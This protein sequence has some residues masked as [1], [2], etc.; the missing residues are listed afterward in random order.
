MIPDR[1]M[2]GKKTEMYIL[3]YFK[4]VK[5]NIA[6]AFAILLPIVM[7]AAGMAIDMAQAYH[8]KERLCGALDLAAVSAAATYTDQDD[9]TSRLNTVIKENFV[10]GRI[11]ELTETEVIVTDDDVTAKAYGVYKTAF[12]HAIGRDTMNVNCETTVKRDVRGLEVALVLDVTGSMSGSNI[13][14]L[15]TASKN[16][17]DIIYD[18]TSDDAFVKIGLVPYSIAVNVGEIAP[19][20]VNNNL[21]TYRGAQVPY[22]YLTEESRLDT[23]VA[24]HGCVKARAYPYDALDESVTDGGYWEP[25]WAP[26]TPFDSKD[27]HWD[28]DFDDDDGDAGMI[29]PRQAECNDRRTPN[30]GCPE[31]N[32]IVPLTSDKQKLIEATENLEFWCRGGTLGNLGMTWGHRILSPGLPFEEGADYDDEKWQ[33]VAVM[34]TDGQNQF[35]DKRTEQSGKDSDFS[36]YGYFLDGSHPLGPS[37]P[38]GTSKRNAEDLMQE[39]FMETCNAMKAD[40]IEIYTIVFGDRL[41]RSSYDGLR[42]DF[43]NCASKPANYYLAPSQADLIAAFEKISKELSIIH[44]TN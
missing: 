20:I 7:G 35:F 19:A 32:P 29:V 34:M 40:D 4:N 23:D 43:K 27:N 6:I 30:L 5:G 17:I 22:R 31:T 16:F 1:K 9:I 25:Y 11:G 21:P 10:A 18:R 42:E 13:S 26:S 36:S 39:R 37:T 28:S 14:A 41:A 38:V 12:M 24:W 3:S 2:T 15:R 44:I 8:M 33:K